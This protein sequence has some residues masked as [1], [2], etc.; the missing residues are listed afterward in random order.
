MASPRRVGPRLEGPRGPSRR[1]RPPGYVKQPVDLVGGAPVPFETGP[2]RLSAAT[3]A[4][5]T[6]EL[7]ANPSSLACEAL[8]YVESGVSP[9]RSPALLRFLASSTPSWL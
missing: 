5:L 1:V 3:P 8:Q 6:L 4:P 2:R 7:R 9:R